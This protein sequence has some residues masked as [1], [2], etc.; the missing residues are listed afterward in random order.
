MAYTAIDK[1]TDYFNTKLTTGTGNSQAVTG[2]GFQ[3][4]WIWGK[5]RDST[6]HHAVFDSVRGITKGLETNQTNPEFTTTDYYSS[7]D[8]DGFTIAAGAGGTGNGSGQTGVHWCWKAGTS[9]TN[10]ASATSIGTIDSTGTFNN[11]S[12]FSI[13]SF[14]GNNTSGATFKHGLNTTPAMVIVQNRNLTNN[15]D[16]VVYHQKL[17]SASYYVY[18]NSSNGQAGTYSNFWNDTAPN[19]SVITLGSGDSGTNGSGDTYIAYCFAEKKGYS[20]CGS[21]TGNGNNDGTFVHTGF[22]PAWILAKNSSASTNWQILDNKRDTF[23]TADNTL[24]PDGNF[25]E[26]NGGDIDFLSNGFKVRNT[27][28]DWNTSG[29]NIIYMAFAEAPLVNSNGIP[30]NAR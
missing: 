9:F 1:P 23:N 14:T 6:G 19:S 22:K 29:Q 11:T 12:G 15:R 27:T 13:V 16:W 7:F 26:G 30:N 25:A 18:L 4:D 2:V 3:P 24:Y 20:K 10:D 21:Y 17:T 8:S 5:R 28:T